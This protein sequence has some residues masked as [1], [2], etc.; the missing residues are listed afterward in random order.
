MAN[1][2]WGQLEKAQDDAETIEEAVARLIAE[3]EADA[4]AHT[5]TGESLETHKSQEVVDH[6][7][8][9]ILP[10]K[11]GNADF[12]IEINYQSLDGFDKYG[13]TEATGLKAGLYVESGVYDSSYINFIPFSTALF[14]NVAASMMLESAVYFDDANES[15]GEISFTGLKFEIENDQVR[16]VSSVNAGATEYTTDWFTVDMTDLHVLRAIHFVLENK[17]RFYVDG[18]LIGTVSDTY[19]LTGEDLTFEA[20]HIR[21]TASDNYLYIMSSKIAIYE[22]Q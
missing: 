20:K 21:N 22:R 16:G 12:F 15:T 8:G 1:P 4:G 13:G 2:V 3:H 6:P 19:S 5:G 14:G 7:Q 18:E 9:S 17:T 10:D 11:K